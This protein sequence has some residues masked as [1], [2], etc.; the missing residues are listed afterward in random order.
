MCGICGIVRKDP[1]CPADPGIL[2]EMT[3]ALA[4]RGPDAA[5]FYQKPGIGM[6]VRRLSIIDIETGNQPM[7]SE[8][9]RVVGM[10]NGEI[11]NYI[12]LRKHLISRGHRFMSRS[13]TE[14]ILH[15]YE[16]EG[17][18][19]VNHLRGMFAFA[20]WDR[21][22]RQCMLARDRLGIKPLYYTLRD[23]GICFGSEIKSILCYP[24]IDREVR[25]QALT[26]L[27]RFGFVRGPGTLFRNIRSLP[28][29]SFLTYRQGHV[30]QTRYWKPDFQENRRLSARDWTDAFLELLEEA[31]R[32]H[33]RSDVEIGAW[34]SPGIDSSSITALMRRFTRQPLHTFTVSFEDPDTDEM[35]HR[36]TLAHYERAGIQA[37]TI[38]CRQDDFKRMPD[39]V[40]HCET[41]FL[42][43]AEIPRL[44]LSEAASHHVKVVMTG[45]GADEI[46]N[47]YPWYRADR[48]LRPLSSLP[49]GFRDSLARFPG[50]AHRFPGAALILGA[51]AE[52]DIRRFQALAGPARS[53]RLGSSLFSESVLDRLL[54]TGY[55]DDNDAG[56]EDTLMNPSWHPSRKLQFL[57]LSLRLPQC[58]MHHLDR[59]SMACSLEA[60]VPFLDHKLVEFCGTMPVRQK[61]HFFREKAVLRRAMAP[62]LPREIIK[63]RKKAMQAPCD[64]WFRHT[65]PGFAADML[66]EPMIARKD[67][68]NTHTVRHLLEEHRQRRCNNGSILMGVLGMQLWDELFLVKP[69]I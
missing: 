19:C 15:L 69:G 60:R 65:M 9:G 25:I 41:P 64:A 56:M 38:V 54:H 26:D 32:L 43:G 10:C 49:Q 27:F 61:L 46:L 1:S 21:Q 44:I 34:L 59:S 14:V 58:V 16:D 33:L 57:D 12:E 48:F 6:G 68:F 45:E 23:D 24:G 2:R 55:D 7:T 42:A 51:P 67:Y 37:H 31:V 47:G 20:L 50:F 62:L 18:Q 13:D 22:R 53:Q 3:A 36:P 35:S 30:S 28:P 40:W 8:D 66:S 39:A 29:G 52:M 5:G 63:R 17:P 4:H 11:Y